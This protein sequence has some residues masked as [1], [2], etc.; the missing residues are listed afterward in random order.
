MIRKII[1]KYRR[2]PRVNQFIKLFSTTFINIPLSIISSVVITRYLGPELF[3]DFT[4]LINIFSFAVIFFDF[5]IFQAGNRALVLSKDKETAKGYYGV[6]LVLLFVLSILMA[7]SLYVY[8]MLDNNLR[9]KDLELALLFLLPFSCL[10]LIPRFY[11]S[12]LHADNRI[13]EL[14]IS[15]FLNVAGHLILYVFAFYLMNGDGYDRL[16]VILSMYLITNVFIFIYL[17]V[18]LKPVLSDFFIRYKE[19]FYYLKKFGLNV[20]IGSVIGVG[21]SQ[22]SGIL[23]SYF[24]VENIGVGFFSLAL[25]FSSPLKMIPNT[26]ATIYYKDFADKAKIPGKLLNTSLFLSI[27]AIAILWLFINPVINF[28]YGEGFS[29]VVRLTYIVSVGMVLYGLADF[30]NRF[31]GAHGKGN[32]LRN[33]AII[34]GIGLLFMNIFLISIWKDIGASIAYVISGIIYLGVMYLYYC[35]YVK[36]NTRNVI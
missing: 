22:L 19:L 21:A 5:G 29:Q 6:L 32:L 10:F 11:E 26:I 28:L 30:Y 17:F 18:V 14:T 8:A 1:D 9:E 23:I 31:L 20:Y 4:F 25:A 2:N 12:L 7:I 13:N 27:A 16:Y 24:S 35:N 36:K 3:G 15:R 33:G 34:V